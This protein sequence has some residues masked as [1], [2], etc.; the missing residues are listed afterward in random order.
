VQR[1]P[2]ARVV[3]PHL[4]N[5]AGLVDDATAVQRLPVDPEQQ[6][7]REHH[8]EAQRHEVEQ[9]RRDY[10][11]EALLVV[12]P[13]GSRDATLHVVPVASSRCDTYSNR[14]M[15]CLSIYLPACLHVPPTVCAAIAAELE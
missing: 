12:I 4:D 2:T 15:K 8:R 3:W 14:G 13:A 10:D 5:V 9:P 1:G 6:E 11:P 7:A